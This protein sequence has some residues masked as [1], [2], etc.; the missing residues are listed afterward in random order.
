MK[1]SFCEAKTTELAHGP[2]VTICYSCIEAGNEVAEAKP[3]QRCSF[4]G[5]MIGTKRS[6]KRYIAEVRKIVNLPRC[7]SGVC[8]Q[9]PFHL[10]LLKT[11]ITAVILIFRMTDIRVVRNGQD[12]VLCNQCLPIARKIAKRRQ[13]QA[14][15]ASPLIQ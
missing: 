11:I 5:E 12:A 13:K 9:L 2:G 6:F 4:C 8:K 15:K 7:S 10:K 3:E 14:L 1:C